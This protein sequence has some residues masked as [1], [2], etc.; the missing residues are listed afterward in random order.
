M[1]KPSLMI[2]LAVSLIDGCMFLQIVLSFT[3]DG[4]FSRTCKG[5][6]GVP[7]VSHYFISSKFSYSPAQPYLNDSPNPQ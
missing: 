5:P 4:L 3:S 2:T 1:M 6:A 7:D